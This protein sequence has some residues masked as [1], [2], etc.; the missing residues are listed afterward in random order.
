MLYQIGEMSYHFIG[1]NDCHARA[2][3]ETFSDA[4]AHYRLNVKFE[5][6]SLLFGRQ[7]GENVVIREL[8]DYSSSFNKSSLIRGV[9]FG[10]SFVASLNPTHHS[11]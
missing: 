1:R 11:P 7:H 9:V 10:I 4:G 6:F 5:N 2:E 8:H 3:N